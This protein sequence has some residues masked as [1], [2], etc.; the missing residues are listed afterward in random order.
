MG[1]WCIYRGNSFRKEEN[2]KLEGNVVAMVMGMKGQG[3]TVR[4]YN[5]F[6]EK[7]NNYHV[8]MFFFIMMVIR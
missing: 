5:D 1:Y 6:N 3:I 2:G 8:I 7:K 4:N